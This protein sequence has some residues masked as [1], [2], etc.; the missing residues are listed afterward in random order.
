MGNQQSQ[1]KSNQSKSY[2]MP[3]LRRS[4]SDT[5]DS[6][7]STPDDYFTTKYCIE[8]NDAEL[9]RLTDAHYI[10]KHI[11]GGNTS[12]PVH[13]LLSGQNFT[14]YSLPASPTSSLFSEHQQN[15]HV[16]DLACGHGVWV[17]EMACAYPHTQ[18]YGIDIY[19]HFPNAIKPSNAHFIQRDLLHPTGLPFPDQHFDYIHM[20]S[21]Y[22]CFS[23]EDVKFVMREIARVLKPGGYLE[24]RDVNPIPKG[25]PTTDD[26]FSDFAER[27]LQYNGVDITWPQ[28]LQQLMT[29]EAGLTEFHQK[30]Y[31][32]RFGMSGPFGT[33]FN[34][35][36]VHACKSYRRFFMES[37]QLSPE[38]CD[39][40]LSE[41]AEE[42]VSHQSY[43][44]HY[45]GWAK[46]PLHGTL[47]PLSSY[48]HT[49][50]DIVHFADGYME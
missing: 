26:F 37:C 50:V 19:N 21:T 9:D 17:M 34:T 46:K 29:E 28:Q 44:Q 13:S 18:F 24:I 33:A 42:C 10:L 23:L 36:V 47:T 30:T 45:M 32:M 35:S 16:L 31:P 12:A 3:L 2:V 14:M 6:Q 40:K 38:A 49:M 41:I 8:M 27:M 15:T 39:Q 43:V 4:S 1:Q 7:C 25:G 20:Q 5:T 11:Y 48:D 22:N